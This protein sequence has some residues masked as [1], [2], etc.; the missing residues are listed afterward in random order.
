MFKL[1]LWTGLRRGELLALKWENINFDEGYINVC[2]TLVNDKHH[3]KIRESTKGN[4]D[5][6]VPLCTE[7]QR[8][9]TALQNIDNRNEGFVFHGNDGEPLS[10]TAYHTRYKK[11][12]AERQAEYPNIPYIPPHK[13]RHTYA[14]YLIQNGADIETA[15]LMLGHSSISTTAIYVHSTFEQMQLAADRLKFT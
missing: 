15:R 8:I 12:Y 1:E 6:R 9:L 4:K 10:F 13:L 11:F 3:A 5:R 14:T 2:Q 7:S